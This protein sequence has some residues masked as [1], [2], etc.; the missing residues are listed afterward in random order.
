MMR[1]I[2]EII[3]GKFPD[4][5]KFHCNDRIIRFVKNEEGLKRA[6]LSSNLKNVQCKE[7]LS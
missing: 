7:I 2:D 4:L 3:K 1:N 5:K 6:M